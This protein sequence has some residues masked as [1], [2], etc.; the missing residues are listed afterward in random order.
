MEIQHATHRHFV[1]K[2]NPET[3]LVLSRQCYHD[4]HRNKVVARLGSLHV[5]C[6]VCMH[7]FSVLVRI[8]CVQYN[9]CFLRL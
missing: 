3:I 5:H 8:V 7:M 6:T 2:S 4:S 9:Y 1:A